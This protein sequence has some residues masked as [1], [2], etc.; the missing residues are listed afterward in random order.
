MTL[1]IAYYCP[2]FSLE[3]VHLYWLQILAP[4]CLEV[5]II[6]NCCKTFKNVVQLSTIKYRNIGKCIT[7]DSQ[8][9]VDVG[10]D[11]NSISLSSILNAYNYNLDSESVAIVTAVTIK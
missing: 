2:L 8:V 5:L 6:I 1:F 4:N 11:V 9:I 3:K 7:G 10:A